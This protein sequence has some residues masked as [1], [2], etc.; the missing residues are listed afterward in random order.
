LIPTHTPKARLR[1]RPATTAHPPTTRSGQTTKLPKR[2]EDYE[3][4]DTEV[5]C[6]DKVEPSVEF[7]DPIALAARSDPDILYYHEILL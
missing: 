3:M 7:S 1:H 4:Y 2:Y 6:P 5:L